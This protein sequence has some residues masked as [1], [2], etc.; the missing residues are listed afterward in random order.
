MYKK[1]F[2]SLSTWFKQNIFVQ[3][4]PSLVLMIYILYKVEKLYEWN[5]RIDDLYKS[6]IKESLITVKV[7]EGDDK[8]EFSRLNLNHRKNNDAWCIKSKSGL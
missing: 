4:Y 6:S 3:K 8:T 5:T 1:V 2:I 7:P